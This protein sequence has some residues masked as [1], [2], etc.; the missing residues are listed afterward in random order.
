MV[1]FLIEQD[2]KA[3]IGCGVCISVCPENW[4]MADDGKA[5]PIKKEVDDIGGNKDAA[6]NCPVACIRIKERK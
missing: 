5:K 4:V 1:K 3:C 6:D 2:R